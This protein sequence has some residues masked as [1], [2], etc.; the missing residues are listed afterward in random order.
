M[1]KERYEL[2]VQRKSLINYNF[3]LTNFLPPPPPLY[4]QYKYIKTCSNLVNSLSYN[5]LVCYKNNNKIIIMLKT[6][7]VFVHF[8][9]CTTVHLY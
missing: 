1:L 9:E 4:R 7:M 5:H 3:R 2:E 6:A 8:V